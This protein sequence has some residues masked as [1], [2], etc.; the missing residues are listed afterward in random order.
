MKVKNLIEKNLN[1]WTKTWPCEQKLGRATKNLGDQT[2]NLAT[3][4]KTLAVRMNYLFIVINNDVDKN[5][6]IFL[7]DKVFNSYDQVLFVENAQVFR[8]I[9]LLFLPSLHTSLYT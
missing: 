1:V 4:T 3:Q 9:N 8:I 2:K 5:P 6:E 7:R